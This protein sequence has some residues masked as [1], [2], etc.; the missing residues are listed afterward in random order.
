MTED[1]AD[2]DVW[3]TMADIAEHLGLRVRS[4]RTYRTAGILP[5]EDHMFGRTPVWRPATITGWQRPGQGAGG[6]R[7]RKD[8][9]VPP[10]LRPQP[11]Q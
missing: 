1:D 10:E 6:G 5:R 8:A 11:P 4:V 3:W 2:R 7:P 9:T